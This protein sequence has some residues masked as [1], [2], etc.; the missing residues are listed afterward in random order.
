VCT[1]A[2][3]LRLLHLPT[4]HVHLCFIHFPL[5]LPDRTKIVS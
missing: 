3:L 2:Q 5:D 4:L 1:A